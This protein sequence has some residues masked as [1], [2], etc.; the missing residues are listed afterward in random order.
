MQGPYPFLQ[1]GEGQK[2][3]VTTL[4]RSWHEKSSLML[5]C[6]SSEQA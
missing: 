3:E 2:F 1:G 4:R 6:V 5:L